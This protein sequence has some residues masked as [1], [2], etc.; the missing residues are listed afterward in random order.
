M[1]TVVWVRQDRDAAPVQ[2][3][4]FANIEVDVVKEAC[5]R[6]LAAVRR[7]FPNSPPDGF[8]I[9]DRERNEMVRWF[10]PGR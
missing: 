5:R 3:E 2:T 10:Y 4:T 8:L 6:R 9:F 1:L 7:E